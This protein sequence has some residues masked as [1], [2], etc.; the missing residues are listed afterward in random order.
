MFN[1]TLSYFIP[2]LLLGV[3]IIATFV[4]GAAR[5]Y[6]L[7]RGLYDVPNARSAHRL[8]TP[9]GGGLGIAAAF[10]ISLIFLER[11]GALSAHVAYALLGGGALVALI[12]WR[13][14]HGHVAARWRILVHTVAA[15]WA[16]FWLGG[17]DTFPGLNVELGMLGAVLGVVGIVWLTNL[18]NFMDGID[19]LAGAQA[20]C[21]G[22][23]GAALLWWGGAP[24]LALVGFS[25]A[26]ASAGFLIWNWPP[27]KIFMGDVGSGLLGFSFA[28]LALAGEKSGALPLLG[29]IVLLAVFVLDASFT[30]LRRM[31]HGEPWLHAHNTHAYQ[32]LV[33]LGYSHLRVTRWVLALNIMIL[34]PLM[35]W[36]WYHPDAALW[37]VLV[38]CVAGWLLWAWIQR[39]F[40]HATGM[41]AR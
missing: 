10:F 4:T 12:G 14:D 29:W 26:A 20:L 21:A 33:Q 11:T 35:G 9:R 16:L 37:V 3:F 27:A 13:D 18:Y 34:W 31:V 30:L 8:P 40:A 22:L 28:V 36:L 39:K 19:G 41:Q 23:G 24:E 17:L 6:A 1:F 2:G 38:T 15:G 25:L 5:Y 32:R 7:R